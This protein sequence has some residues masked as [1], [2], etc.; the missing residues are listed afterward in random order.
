[1]KAAILRLEHSGVGGCAS[2]GGH[3]QV[4]P[5]WACLCSLPYSR[6]LSRRSCLRRMLEGRQESSGTGEGWTALTR[7]IGKAERED[8]TSAPAGQRHA[9][10]GFDRLQRAIGSRVVAR[11]VP[12]RGQV[13]T[14][15]S[16][17]SWCPLSYEARVSRPVVRPFGDEN[18]RSSLNR[19]S[20]VNDD[21]VARPLPVRFRRV[22]IGQIERGKVLRRPGTVRNGHNSQATGLPKVVTVAARAMEQPQFQGRRVDRMRRGERVTVLDTIN[23]WRL[24]V[25]PVAGPG[26]Y[27]GAGCLNEPSRY[28]GRA[29]QAAARVEGKPRSLAARKGHSCDAEGISLG[30]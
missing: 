21:E 15:Q 30:P 18:S 13:A 24:V 5:T 28:G 9:M 23:G 26:G 6:A 1:M 19:E 4:S 25:T 17:L 3:A 20:A 22:A 14:S 27:S 7:R 16:T 8:E 2:G 29:R 11:L 12:D 10:Q